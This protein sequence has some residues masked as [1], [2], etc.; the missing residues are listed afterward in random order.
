MGCCSLLKVILPLFG[1]W[2]AFIGS[3]NI[4]GGFDFTAGFHKSNREFFD[5]EAAFKKDL[6]L[7]ETFSGK[8]FLH[9]Q[10]GAPRMAVK[11]SGLPGVFLDYFAEVSGG[12]AD[13]KKEN[14]EQADTY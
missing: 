5:D 2:T 9:E 12:I 4:K 8:V 13:F 11:G 10:N 14:N 1:A 3:L 6:G 7:L